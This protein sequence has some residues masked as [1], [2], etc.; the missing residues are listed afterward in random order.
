M[1]VLHVYTHKTTQ[2]N[3]LTSTFISIALHICPHARSSF[4][5]LLFLGQAADALALAAA[6]LFD[7]NNEHVCPVPLQVLVLISIVECDLQVFGSKVSEQFAMTIRLLSVTGICCK[8]WY[9]YD[10][11]NCHR[12]ASGA[13][14][15]SLS[16]FSQGLRSVDNQTAFALRRQHRHMSCHI[17][18]QTTQLNVKQR[19]T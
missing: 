8:L 9:G 10:N 6:L 4:S 1:I 11:F 16:R 18:M 17:S 15:A 3:T 13:A 5:F 14:G 19:R 12:Q 7:F 2:C